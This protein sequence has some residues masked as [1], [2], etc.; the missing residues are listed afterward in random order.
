MALSRTELHGMI[1]ITS[2]LLGVVSLLAL[3]GWLQATGYEQAT[4][5]NCRQ[6]EIIPEKYIDKVPSGCVPQW[7]EA[8]KK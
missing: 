5:D 8:N 1:V 6:Y 4:R 2:I 7:F 3:I